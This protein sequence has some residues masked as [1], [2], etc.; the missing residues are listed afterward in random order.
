MVEQ[1]SP[2]F[3]RQYTVVLSAENLV[4]SA[5]YSSPSNYRRKREGPQ[6]KRENSAKRDVKKAE[7]DD[8]WMEKAGNREKWEGITAG[9][10]HELVS[11]L[12][13]MEQ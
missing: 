11:P 5:V 1:V 13:K 4:H 10:V 6:L 2:G 8:K 9:T 3:V 7:E 12:Y